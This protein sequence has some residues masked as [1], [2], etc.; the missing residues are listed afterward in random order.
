MWYGKMITLG[1]AFILMVA[2]GP[3]RAA[4]LSDAEILNRTASLRTLAVSAAKHY[5]NGASQIQVAESRASMGASAAAFGENLRLLR[6][7]APNTHARNGL[8]QLDH[9]WTEFRAMLEA[10][11][12]MEQVERLIETSSKLVFLADS[13]VSNW[14]G[15]AS[16]R[17]LEAL[18]LAH[19]QAMLSERIGLLYSAHYYGLTNDWIVMELNATLHEYERGLGFL[20]RF[21]NNEQTVA[22]HLEQ[23]SNQWAYA[24]QGFSRF[25]QGQYLPKVIAVT[26]D[27]MGN[28]MAEMARYYT[29]LHEDK[30]ESIV[31]LSVPGLAANME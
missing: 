3:G 11:P 2:S 13:L 29:A 12:S 4:V 23:V 20:D 31:T 18:N 5:V 19:M 6:M 9:E 26:V 14:R 1:L 8:K 24:K 15:L 30:R 28:E 17:D 7:Q 22:D 21:L 25:N 27:S 10:K 16:D